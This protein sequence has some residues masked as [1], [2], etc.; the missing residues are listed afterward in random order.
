MDESPEV[1]MPINHLYIFQCHTSNI[2][3]I[4][5]IFSNQFDIICKIPLYEVTQPGDHE[6][7]W[8][9]MLQGCL[10]IFIPTTQVYIMKIKCSA[11]IPY[12]L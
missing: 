2:F 6:L 9:I 12:N 11:I 10:T 8:Y 3:I 7:L 5:G 4:N 1:A